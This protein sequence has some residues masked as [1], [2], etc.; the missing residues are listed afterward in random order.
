MKIKVGQT[1]RITAGPIIAGRGGFGD[2]GMIESISGRTVFVKLDRAGTV[3]QFMN[4]LEVLNTE[5][6][7]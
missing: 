2:V 4:E 7:R 3:P 5:K 1:V 6:I